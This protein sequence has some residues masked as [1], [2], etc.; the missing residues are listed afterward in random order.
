MTEEQLGRLRDPAFTTKRHAGGGRGIP[1]LASLCERT[2]G[3]LEVH[4]VPE[5]EGAHHGTVVRAVIPKTAIDSIPLG[6]MVG[7]VA[8]LIAGGEG[9]RFSFVHKTDDGTV[10]FDTDELRPV[11]GDVSSANP[12]VLVFIKRYLSGQ[13]DKL[14]KKT[15]IRKEFQS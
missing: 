13:Y 7:T 14:I 3:V 6:D 10:S 9:V 2:G 8:A 12:E 1:S 4:S 11:L 15:D 5:S